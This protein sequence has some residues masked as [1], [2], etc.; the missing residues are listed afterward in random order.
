MSSSNVKRFKYQQEI[1]DKLKPKNREKSLRLQQTKLNDHQRKYLEFVMDMNQ[2][3]K[4][5]RPLSV[6]ATP[7]T[8]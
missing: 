5:D 6:R 1:I 4:L 2:M 7:E 3:M 8:G